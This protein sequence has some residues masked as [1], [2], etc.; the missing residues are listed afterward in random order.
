[1]SYYQGRALREDRRPRVAPGTR[2]GR[3]ATMLA[4]FGLIALLA[5][6]PWG[7][8]RARLA[9]LGDVRVEGLHY[10]DASRVIAQSGV[11][12]GEDALAIDLDAVRQRL[13]M[14]PRI[15][16]AEVKRRGPRALTLTIRERL[17]VLLVRHGVPWELDSAGV[18][19]A[20]LGTGAVADVPLLSGPD[21]ESLPPGSEVKTLE[22][23]RGL[24]WVRA[25]SARELQLAGQVSELDVSRPESTGLLLM[26]G[27]RV[28][29]PAW[30]PGMDRLSA[31]QV[32]LAD[33][34]ARGT[35]AGEVDLRFERQV[36]V[37][38]AVPAGTA[39]AARSS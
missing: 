9:P 21:F 17:P 24:A 11:K 34:R 12:S 33:L 32:V 29:T 38:P 6:L 37:R 30:P 31:L 14:H 15:A 10:L 16:A 28:L 18:L 35:V 23:R 2:V 8:W 22:V 26:N 20:P 25:L 39:M 5:Q 4:A 19:L 1:M 27:T 3:I 13:L 7:A 36:I